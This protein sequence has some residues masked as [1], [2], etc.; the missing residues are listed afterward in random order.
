MSSSVNSKQVAVITG[1]SS[2]IGLETAKILSRTCVVY[3]LSRKEFQFDGLKHICADVCDDSSVSNAISK[4][5]EEEGRIDILV[6]CAGSGISGAVEFT[7]IGDVTKQV[8][9]VFKGT[10]NAVHA[11][12]PQMRKQKSGRIV[13][14]SSVA[15][16]API[17]FQTYYSASKSAVNTFVCATANEVR[18]YGI[19]ICAVMPGDTKT[20]FTDNRKKIEKGGEEYSGR[21]S[22]SV[23]R[24][25]E[26]EK[27]GVPA[28]KVGKFIADKSLA[29]HVKPLYTVGFSYKLITVA[30][31]ILPIRFANWVLYKMYASE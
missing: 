16:V 4:V 18:P 22:K 1:G 23:R 11:V 21:I 19:T 17:P 26:D 30:L 28:E 7:D 31:K 3:V 8:D 14:V 27:N 12:L 9:V 2:G 5:I 25:E 24:M 15:A 20:G 6:T 10:V 29:S 13:C